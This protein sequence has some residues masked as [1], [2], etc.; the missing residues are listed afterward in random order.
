MK[1]MYNFINKKANYYNRRKIAIEKILDDAKQHHRYQRINNT[2][3]YVTKLTAQAVNEA[4]VDYNQAKRKYDFWHKVQ[5]YFDTYEQTFEVKYTYESKTHTKIV[6][7]F[8]EKQ[9][10][11]KVK[12]MKREPRVFS[13]K[14][15]YGRF[16]NDEIKIEKH[17]IN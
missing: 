5:D 6:N 13:S 10:E 7:A 8:D 15:V 14:Q 2:G 4:Q 3:T 16:S 17:K 11:A 12:A 1:S 9:A